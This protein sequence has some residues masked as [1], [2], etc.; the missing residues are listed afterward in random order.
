MEFDILNRWTGNVLL[1]AEIEC[2]E[3]APKSIKLGLAVKWAVKTGASLVGASLVGARLD[4][5][6]LVCARLDGA[7]LDGAR[8]DF[9]AWPLYCGSKNA[10]ADDRLVSQLL[11][12]VVNLDVTRCSGGVREA[13]EFLRKMGVCNL[14]P[15]YRADTSKRSEF[16]ADNE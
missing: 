6:S 11:F 3:S 14:F 7:S 4:G 16:E 12:H 10:I 9:S 8:L 13:V 5:V 1:T 15:E 2:D